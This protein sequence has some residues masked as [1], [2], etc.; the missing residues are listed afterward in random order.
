MNIY[1][2]I[3]CLTPSSLVSDCVVTCFPFIRQKRHQKCNVTNR[4]KKRFKIK[5]RTIYSPLQR[6]YSV[7]IKKYY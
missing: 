3:Y 5:K 4:K 1:I 7:R 2:Y 6:E